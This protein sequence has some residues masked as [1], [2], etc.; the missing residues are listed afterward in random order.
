[1]HKTGKPVQPQN[2][3]R[4][5]TVDT[6][7]DKETFRLTEKSPE[8]RKCPPRIQRGKYSSEG[9]NSKIMA[10]INEEEEGAN[11]TPK[12]R[13]AKIMAEINEEEEGVNAT[14]KELN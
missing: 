6:D 10:E 13:N 8:M 1:M 3:L 7:E 9:A 14:P 4:F 11:T 5:F 2:T 12:E